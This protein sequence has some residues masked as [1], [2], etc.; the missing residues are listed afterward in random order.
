MVQDSRKIDDF[1]SFD[2]ILLDSP[3]SGS[4]TLNINDLDKDVVDQLMNSNGLYF[5]LTFDK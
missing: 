5:R 4:G 2:N 1:F 3:C